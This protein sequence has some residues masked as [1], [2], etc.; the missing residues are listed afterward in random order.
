METWRV[1]LSRGEMQAAWDLFID[2][3]RRLILATIRRTIQDDE[4]VLDAFVHVCD[5]LSAHEFARL[6]KYTDEHARKARFSTWLVVVV[7]NLTIDWVRQRK[8]RRRVTRPAGLSPIQQQIFDHIFVDG[9]SRDEAYELVNAENAGE[10][11]F[12]SFLQ[13]VA[14]TYRRVDRTGTGGVMRYFPAG[15]DAEAPA[16]SPEDALLKSEIG[17]QMGKALE[18]LPADV[19]LA[20][21]LFVVDRLPAADVARIVRWPNAKAVYNRVSRALLTLR[22]ELD[23]LG[24]RPGDLA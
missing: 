19:R 7:R 15:A 1:R 6:K 22:E 9:R 23:R 17:E 13:E 24:I 21:Q 5:A 14:K 3:Y 12:G 20:I 2:R 11:P 18:D 8:G 16:A 10:L 4:D